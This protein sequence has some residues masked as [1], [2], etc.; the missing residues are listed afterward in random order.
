VTTDPRGA[1][2]AGAGV[3]ALLLCAGEGTRLR[4]LTLTRPKALIEIAGRPMV[5]HLLRWLRQA[6]VTEIAINLHH[7]P[8]AIPAALGTGEEWGVRLTYS[9][10]PEIRG[11][12]GAARQLADWL[13]DP[14][15]VVYGDILVDI[16]L[17]PLFEMHRERGAVATIGLHP[18]EDPTRAGIV[19]TDPDGRVRRFVE[20][21]AAD[22]LPGLADAGGVIQCNGGVYL[23]RRDVLGRIPPN[24]AYD[25]GYDLFPALLAEGAPIYA[26]PLPG[27]I[28]DL[29]SHERL[30][31]AAAD[32]AAGRVR[33]PPDPGP[34]A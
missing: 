14:F 23:I 3:R 27:Y 1:P 31:Q 11:T 10:E 29:G 16:D 12:A 34:G 24:Q 13:S 17:G 5:V 8:E 9:R 22:E 32:I 2:A 25:F 30:A 6:G 21:P 28:L 4:P 15:L 33:L 20:K 19:V 7:L 26:A 18:V